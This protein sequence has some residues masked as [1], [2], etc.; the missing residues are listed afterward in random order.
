M[1]T[2]VKL[3]ARQ[4]LFVQE[5]LVDLNATQAAIRAGYKND[6][7][8]FENLRKPQIEQAI[9]LAFQKRAE[10]IGITQ[11]WVLETLKENVE[12]AMA[13]CEVLDRNGDTTGVY[14]YQGGIANRALELLGKHIGMWPNKVEHG[15]VGGTKNVLIK[16]V[17]D[18]AEND[19]N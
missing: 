4:R 19:G 13:T 1:T 10:R 18:D 11:D 17:Y 5:Y 8:G 14:V 6:H 7:Q 9:Q 16:V 3:T 12:R 2:D 15:G